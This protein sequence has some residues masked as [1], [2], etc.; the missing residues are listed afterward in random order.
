MP[1]ST[2]LHTVRG[3]YFDTENTISAYCDAA[4]LE[5]AMR[6]CS[7]Y[8]NLLSKTTPGSDVWRINHAEGAP[9]PVSAH[10]L[11]ILRTA[12][13][14]SQASGGAF[15]IAVGPA[16][17]L[18]RFKDTAPHLPDPQALAEAIARADYTQIALDETSVTVPATMQIDLG[19]IAKGYIADCI[20]A[21]LREQGVASALLNFGGN[22]VTIGTKP[23]GSPWSIGLQTPDGER[24]KAFWAAVKSVDG[25]VVTSGVYE[26]GFEID[27]VRYH[28]ILDPR[29]GWPVQNGLLTVTACTQSSLLAD[30]LTT[31]MFV[32]GP[33]AGMH[34]AHQFGVQAVFLSRDGTVTYTQGMDLV[35]VQPE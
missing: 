31:A 1:Q 28:H 6:R 4:L 21:E 23:D 33:Q 13:Q 14:V 30:A 32:L 24:G 15:N 3:F 19:G 16:I 5:A 10:T 26:R 22:V 18:W 25:T 35:L 8:H 7:D 12:A 34:L 9:T 20:A 11:N 17:A 27:G 29:T 2:T